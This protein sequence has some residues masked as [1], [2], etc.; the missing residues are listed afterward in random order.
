MVQ[1][2]SYVDSLLTWVSVVEGYKIEKD[3]SS[4]ALIRFSINMPE[5]RRPLFITYNTY[6]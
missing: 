1:S 4:L 6:I 5:M 2:E 3:V